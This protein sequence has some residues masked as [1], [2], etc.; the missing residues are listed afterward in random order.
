MIVSVINIFSASARW[1]RQAGHGGRP[2]TD[3]AL[4]PREQSSTQRERTWPPS[5]VLTLVVTMCGSGGKGQGSVGPVT[6]P[7]TEP[8]H[9]E[10]EFMKTLS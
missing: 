1:W 9:K 10:N 3:L 6:I 4:G 5:H 7:T 2:D 8:E